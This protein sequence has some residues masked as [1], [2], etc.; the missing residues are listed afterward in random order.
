MESHSQK[1]LEQL[2]IA[3][4]TRQYGREALVPLRRATLVGRLPLRFV[5]KSRSRR[6]TNAAAQFRRSFV[7]FVR[8]TSIPLVGPISSLPDRRRASYNDD[9]Y[10]D[11]GAPSVRI[12]ARRRRGGIRV[13]LSDQSHGSYPLGPLY[14][15]NTP[16]PKPPRNPHP[17]A[18]TRTRIP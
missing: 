6:L 2:P 13:C 18:H 4:F 15:K 5:R 14:K 9:S 16:P 17:S 1:D 11:E 7:S 3:H 8:V 10:V 12:A